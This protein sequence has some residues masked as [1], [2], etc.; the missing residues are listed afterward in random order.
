MIA[1]LEMIAEIMKVEKTSE[2]DALCS[3]I[4]GLLW[5]FSSLPYLSGKNGRSYLRPD[6]ILSLHGSD[7]NTW[8][9][10]ESPKGI[11]ILHSAPYVSQ[12]LSPLQLGF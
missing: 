1:V 4:P 10:L 3:L 6:P 9:P 2:V 12:H 7:D 8:Q 11:W 5:V